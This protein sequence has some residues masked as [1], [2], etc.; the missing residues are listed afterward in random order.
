MKVDMVLELCEDEEWEDI[1]DHSE[2]KSDPESNHNSSSCFLDSS[3]RSFLCGYTSDPSRDYERKPCEGCKRPLSE[4]ESEAH[5]CSK[6]PETSTL[7]PQ[8]SKHYHGCNRTISGLESETHICLSCGEDPVCQPK[9]IGTSHSPPP[10]KKK[11]VEIEERQTCPGVLAS[12]SPITGHTDT[13]N[14]IARDY[15]GGAAVDFAR[16]D[17]LIAVVNVEIVPGTA[18]KTYFV[19]CKGENE[20]RMPYLYICIHNVLGGDSLRFYVQQE[21]KLNNIL[22][23]SDRY[24]RRCGGAADTPTL[25]FRDQQADLDVNVYSL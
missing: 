20:W 21:C 18:P 22:E 12:S 8:Q 23:E 15:S 25:K 7:E 5:V 2:V 9:T 14:S 11:R 4:K 10:L 17:S 13:D 16:D 3:S 19:G 6:Q 24:Y 1:S